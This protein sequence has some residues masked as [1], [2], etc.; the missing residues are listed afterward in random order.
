MIH[1]GEAKRVARLFQIAAYIVFLLLPAWSGD[2]SI[3]YPSAD[4]LREIKSYRM[5]GEVIF[6]GMKGKAEIL[7]GAPDKLLVD[8]R[9]DQW[10]FTQGFDGRKAWLRDHNGQVVELTGN[11]RKKAINMTFMAGYSFAVRDRMPGEIYGVGD[12]L[13]EGVRYAAY[14]AFPEGGDSLFFFINKANGQMEIAEEFFDEISLRTV[15]SDFRPVGG[16]LF[17]FYIRGLSQIE[18]LNSILTISKME[19]N[20]PIADS[21]FEFNSESKLDFIFPGG[22]DL[23][24]VPLKFIKGHIFVE[25]KINDSGDIYFMLDTGAGANVLDKDFAA[26]MNLRLSGDIASKGVAG[27]ESFSMTRVDS[28]VVKDVSLINQTMAAADLS[29]LKKNCPGKLG[30]ILGFDFF[31]RFPIRISYRDSIMTVFNPGVC[32]PELSENAVSVDFIMKIP[33][34]RAAIDNVTGVFLIDLG[35][36]FGLILH[37]S[38]V[39]NNNLKANF[40]DI[41]E[42]GTRISGIGGETETYE[43]KAKSFQIGNYVIYNPRLFVASAEAG[44]VKS[45]NING[46]IGNKIL[47]HF[48]LT[49]DYARNAID[50]VSRSEEARLKVEAD[51]P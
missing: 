37:R 4:S 34:V 11:E 13:I 16:G 51:E 44:L 22:V 5:L 38:F 25:V 43:A 10:Q 42:G 29:A 6:G 33:S 7:Y 27:Y 20:V 41:I 46:N 50:I 30:G 48:D 47:M 45:E 3:P 1:R 15:Y 17:P 49:F 21:I 19:I 14:K 39:D 9:L 8:Y 32:R 2:S 24:V 28:L 12:T 26:E 23:V 35:N 18:R 36:S 31:S 40:A